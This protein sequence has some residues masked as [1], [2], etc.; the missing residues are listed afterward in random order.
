MILALPQLQ[1]GVS[2]AEVGNWQR[3]LNYV[4]IRDASGA[5]LVADEQF[6][7]RT[8]YATSSYQA[9]QGLPS[10]GRV[11]TET[12][13]RARSQGFI[14]F[15]QARGIN[16]TSGRKIR[17]LVIHTMESSEKPGTAENVALWFAGRTQYPAPKASAH[18]NIDPGNI[19]QSVRERDI[20]WAAPGANNDGIH[21]E[22]AGRASQTFTDWHDAD[23]RAIISRSAGLAADICIR[24][25]LPVR[26]LLKSQILAGE[27]GLCGHDTI[28]AA[29][30][31]P[32]RTH[33]D[34]GPNFPWQEYLQKVLRRI[35]DLQP[36]QRPL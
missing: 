25:N 9:S 1:K 18:Y 5:E 29:Y 28:T 11:D 23:S 24:H 36:T 10:T 21:L 14:P 20:A 7:S 26:L 34:P 30:P 33:W 3:F 16:Y 19:V 15:I 22:H 27:K 17:L 8:K 4:G 32:G 13:K 35:Q 31:G 12:R 2:V 6:G